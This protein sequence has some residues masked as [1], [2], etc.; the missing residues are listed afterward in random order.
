MH[1]YHEARA[2]LNDLLGSLSK[3]GIVWDMVLLASQM[4][5]LGTLLPDFSLTDT[6]GKAVRSSDFECAPAL[7]VVFLCS[8]CPYTLHI[9]GALASFAHEYEAR[10]LA[11]VGIN[12]NDATYPEDS[13]ERMAEEKRVAGYRFPY[14]FDGT[15]QIARALHAACTPDFFLFDGA[16]RLAYRGQ[17]DDTRPGKGGVATGADLRTACD[18]VL[19]R[20]AVPPNQKPSMGCNIK[21]SRANEP[22][23]FSPGILYR[24]VQRLRSQ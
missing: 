16:R 3:C 14:L 21:W 8:H 1:A 22:D 23:Y 24:I 6:D 11:V 17:F 18:A 7:L 15:Q 20:T 4:T 9:R 2:W 10:G 13:P 19:A 5:R 12:A